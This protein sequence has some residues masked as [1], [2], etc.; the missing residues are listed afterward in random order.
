[1]KKLIFISLFGFALAIYAAC[2]SSGNNSNNGGSCASTTALQ[3]VFSPM[4]SAYDGVHR[5]QVPVIVNGID[6]SQVTWSTS[7]TSIATIQADTTVGGGMVTVQNSGMVT[8]TAQAGNLCGTSVLTIDSAT[9]DE[10]QQGSDRYNNGILFSRQRGDM[11]IPDGSSSMDPACTNCHGPTAM[12]RFTDVAHTPEQIGG[13]SDDVLTGVMRDGVVPDGGYFDT[14][15]IPYM[16]WHNLHQWQFTDEDVKGVIVYLRSLTP[17]AQT[18][19]ANFG[20]MG[21]RDGGGF[22]GPRDMSATD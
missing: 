21:P 6:P 4:Y 14:T 8:I 18:G 12:G 16:F 15:I 3:V 11:G 1:M 17:T 2:S 5:F 22:G 9:P 20:G 19:S 10:W 13:F 7:D